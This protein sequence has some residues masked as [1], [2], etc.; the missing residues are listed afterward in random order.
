MFYLFVDPAG[1]LGLNPSFVPNGDE[2]SSRFRNADPLYNNALQMILEKTKL[3][4][5][6]NEDGEAI[7]DIMDSLARQ[8]SR[9]DSKN[10]QEPVNNVGLR[11]VRRKARAQVLGVSNS[12]LMAPFTTSQAISSFI[13]SASRDHLK[14]D[15]ISNAIRERESYQK[16]ERITLRDATETCRTLK[17]VVTC[18]GFSASL[19]V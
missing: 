1:N 14:G 13:P 15:A 2:I 18:V 4:P 11:E 19:R 17:H 16:R 5:P 8:P 12:K 7:G 3:S 10:V 9:K 6:I